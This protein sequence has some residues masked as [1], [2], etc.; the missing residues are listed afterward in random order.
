MIY[1]FNQDSTIQNV[2]KQTGR[3]EY[4]RQCVHPYII[5]SP[6][7]KNGVWRESASFVVS[8]AMRHIRN[9]QNYQLT[10]KAGQMVRGRIQPAEALWNWFLTDIRLTCLKYFSRKSLTKNHRS[11]AC[12]KGCRRRRRRLLNETEIGDMESA[13]RRAG[14]LQQTS[15]IRRNRRNYEEICQATWWVLESHA[16]DKPI[17]VRGYKRAGR[18]N[19]RFELD[20]TTPLFAT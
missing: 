14:S 9:G 3:Y 19:E 7:R 20:G 17:C 5:R 6:A 8:T 16:W 15:R 10:L 13:G 4:R 1:T 18:S 2:E 11:G 12:R